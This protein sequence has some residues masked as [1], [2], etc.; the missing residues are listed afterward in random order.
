[1]PTACP[2]HEQLQSLVR[3]E[4]V[5]ALPE[6]LERHLET[7]ADCQQLLER[8]SSA[9]LNRTPRLSALAPS[10]LLEQVMRRLRESEATACVATDPSLEPGVAPRSFGDYEIL[11]ELGRGG[12]GVVYRARQ[13]SLNRPVALKLILAGQLASP[14][15]V[16][17]F[18][19]EAEAAARMHHP[20]IV[21]IYEIG[22]HEGR[23]FLS[24]KLIEGEPL[25]ARLGKLRSQQSPRQMATLVSRVA[26]AVHYA[27]QRSILHRDLKPANILLDQEDQPHLTDFGLAKLLESDAGLT[28]SQAVMGTPDYLSPE[29][30]AGKAREVTTAADIFSL[31]A[32]LYE[33]LTGSPPF[34][35]DTAAAT[36]QKVLNEEP[37]PP[38]SAV[39][40]VPRDL[41]TIALKCLEKDPARRYASA[42]EVA[43]EL[44]R[45]ARGETILA[46][47]ATPPERVWR[48]ARRKPALATLVVALH[49]VFAAGLAG[50]L[51]QWQRANQH[52]ERAAT[53]AR[54][55]AGQ[56]RTAEKM[57]ER[58]AAQ[59]E[60]AEYQ[61]AELLLSRGELELPLALL[62]RSLRESPTN[63]VLAT[64]IRSVLDLRGISLP[65]MA[66]LTQ[67]S[68]IR[69]AR[70]SPDGKT[71]LTI[72]TDPVA[73][74]WPAEDGQPPKLLPHGGAITAFAFSATAPLLVTA[75]EL[76]TMR[77]WSS[78][79]G[80]PVGARIV[81]GNEAPL[82]AFNQD[83][84][85]MI[86]A[87]ANML[88]LWEMPATKQLA[89]ARPGL[90]QPLRAAS[91]S[92]DGRFLLTASPDTSVI[93]EADTL[94][95]VGELPGTSHAQFTPDGGHLLLQRS[96]I[97]NWREHQPLTTQF[98][99]GEEPMRSA[100]FS[101]DGRSL[102]LAAG[103]WGGRL[104]DLETLSP[105]VPLLTHE[106][107]VQS[108]RFSR[109]G[110]RMLT[111]TASGLV[112]VWDARTG[113]P[114]TTP[115]HHPNEIHF[116]EFSPDSQRLLILPATGQVHV[117]NLRLH[118]ARSLRLLHSGLVTSVQFASEGKRLLTTSR[119][120]TAQ[121]W[122]RDTGRLVFPPLQ[123]PGAV[124]AAALSPDGRWI[125]TVCADQ[126][127]RLWSAETGLPRGQPLVHDDTPVTVEF[128]PDGGRLVTAARD[129][130]ARVWDTATGKLLL[131]VEQSD[132]LTA[133]HFSED[134]KQLLTAA[135]DG[136]AQLWDAQ[137]GQ[138]VFSPF[139]HRNAVMAAVFA[140][141]G[142]HIATSSRDRTLR[143]WDR[144]SGREAG[145]PLEHPA[146]LRLEAL[147]FSPD[148][149]RAVTAAG[150]SA[151]VWNLV[152]G[153]PVGPPLSH[154]D[155]VLDAQFSP[156]GRMVA[157]VSRDDT[158][159]FWDFTTGLPLSEPLPHGARVEHL[160]FSPD[161]RWLA[162]AAAD[163]GVH[164]WEVPR[165]DQPIPQWLPDLAEAMS[166]RRV[167]ATDQA[168]PVSPT[169]LAKMRATI[170]SSR[171][172]DDFSLWARW[173]LSRDAD[174]PL[175]PNTHFT[176]DDYAALLLSGKN[177]ERLQEAVLLAPTNPQA[178]ARLA[179]ALIAEAGPDATQSLRAADWHSRYA[180]ALAPADPM[181]GE[182]RETVRLALANSP[183]AT[184]PS[185]PGSKTRAI[186]P[187][188][189]SQP[190]RR[191]R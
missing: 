107:P 55:E 22:E 51:W 188:T 23:H 5:E 25:S 81:H 168:E 52:A 78:A 89:S 72:S 106:Q 49:L 148:G 93:W 20:G 178:H 177:V 58:E 108:A 113:Q 71:I 169:E 26:Q 145:P 166:R 139:E 158:A 32:I 94:K 191:L 80:T 117:W 97:W 39:P 88:R 44:D 156:D 144:Q 122:E 33:L 19:N 87:S 185:M 133:A 130:L 45:F 110:S 69:W 159:R 127:A 180:E 12:M 35:G 40:G 54:S 74:L 141:D 56:R 184:A 43:E 11:G 99:T 174:R 6:S 147:H 116:A 183:A 67:P 142:K 57:V 170:E 73:R 102:L 118:G 104:L 149:K 37:R 10:P 27:H 187:T 132:A 1:M 48:W 160:A 16:R 124:I 17:R 66:P 157:T 24:M 140:P 91:F 34:H 18:Q 138:T 120:G 121:L 8:L 182:I 163:G 76:G 131:K 176:A 114:L 179:R 65:A 115:I 41:E 96:M 70:Y 46:R 155:L 153:H 21:P 123:H 181:V 151:Y 68:P 3:G 172:T 173:L 29:V 62:A 30:A 84:R 86:S 171:A 47:P 100:E 79:D 143:F 129:G 36:I 13:I 64:R 59:H 92:P 82:L 2:S 63:A 38:R 60:R 167:N 105:R 103:D 186:R 53:F 101:P 161:G 125:A 83:G 128:A 42:A 14:A 111:I 119:D 28:H 50:I 134:G 136:V 15:E 164:V 9:N 31:G 135:R 190:T 77:L 165:L 154:G 90:G 162:T 175:S 75:T 61:R 7:C 152:G 137:S 4:L 85:R 189:S 112:Y 150:N 98:E 146:G 109:D 95:R 126:T